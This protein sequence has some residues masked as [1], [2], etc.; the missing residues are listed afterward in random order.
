MIELR[1]YKFPTANSYHGEDPVWINPELITHMTVAKSAKE[2][3]NGTVMGE[4]ILTTIIYFAVRDDEGQASIIV[5]ESPAEIIHNIT[6]GR[7]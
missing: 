1:E 2:R 5:L 6:Y 4:R 7:L 3:N